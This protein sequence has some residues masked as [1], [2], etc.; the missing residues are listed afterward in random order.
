MSV[1]HVYSSSNILLMLAY[2]L[3][4]SCLNLSFIASLELISNL[5][6]LTLSTTFPF[7]TFLIEWLTQRCSV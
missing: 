6:N 4:I 2:F 1:Q 3:L 7:M 5:A